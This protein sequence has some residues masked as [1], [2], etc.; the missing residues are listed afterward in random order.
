MKAVKTAPYDSEK[1]KKAPN[2]KSSESLQ[3]ISKICTITLL[4][5]ITS[6]TNTVLV[7]K[8]PKYLRKFRKIS[9][10]YYKNSETS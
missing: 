5:H 10:I 7:R 9:Q 8:S 3:N 1:Y 2:L 6:E 4:K